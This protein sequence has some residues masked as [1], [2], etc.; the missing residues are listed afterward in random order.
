[1]TGRIVIIGA[2]HG[3]VTAAEALRRNG[4]QGEITLL[5]A[6]TMA[7]YHRPPLSKAYLSG[8][9][10]AAQIALRG[11]AFYTDNRIDLRLGTRATGLDP[12]ARRITTAAGAEI[13]YDRLILATGAR[14]RRLPGTEGLAHVHALRDLRDADRLRDVMAAGGRLAIVGGG[15]I[16]LE[17]AASMVK[18]GVA[19][20][21]IEPLPA[22]LR[23]ALPAEI[24]DRVQ[25]RH[26]AEGVDLRLG[27][28]VAELRSGGGAFA[29]LLLT[30]GTEIAADHLLVG[31]GSTARLE[32]AEAAGADL[33]LGG[34]RVDA[35]GQSSVPGIYAIG[36][37]ATQWNDFYGDWIRIE[38][39]QAATD[40]ARAVAAH[41]TGRD[42]VPGAGAVLPWFWSDQYDL[43]L[44]MAGFVQPGADV[45]LRGDDAGVSV[46][47]LRDG[48]LTAGFS[49]NRPGDHV[50]ARKFI[51]AE[52]RMDPDALR[53]PAVALAKCLRAEGI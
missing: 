14:A 43:K 27:T 19:V 21:V 29:G 48:R 41:I 26:L 38:S 42:A 50:G 34:V 37:C 47:H 8:D 20:T 4:W 52:A 17:V 18:A 53:D 23:R 25:A 33:H 36:D 40:Q 15:F 44:Q 11:P 5:S 6:E 49:V 13:G 3:G 45:V 31:I 46:L 2:A 9:K 51:T 10:T 7:P 39:V 12:A 22:L 30:D 1:M 28:G 24:S 35:F 16:G 32:L